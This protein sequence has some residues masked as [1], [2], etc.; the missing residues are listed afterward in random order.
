MYSTSNVNTVVHSIVILNFTAQPSTNY[1]G[2]LQ[3]HDVQLLDA[4]SIVSTVLECDIQPGALRQSYSVLWKQLQHNETS[5]II[6]DNGFNL[7]LSVNYSVD[8]SQYQCEV[9]IDHDGEGV[10]MTYEGR[11]IIIRGIHF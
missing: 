11:T 3:I 7:T 5:H 1:S 6:N 9:T 8:G 4:D 10:S 2:V